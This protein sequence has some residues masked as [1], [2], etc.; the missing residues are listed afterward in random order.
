MIRNEIAEF[1]TGCRECYIQ[2]QNTETLVIDKDCL[3]NSLVNNNKTM[4]N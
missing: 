2:K 3:V 1:V 4:D